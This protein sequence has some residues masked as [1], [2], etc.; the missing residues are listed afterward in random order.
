[1][2]KP[3][4]RMPSRSDGLRPSV[5]NDTGLASYSAWIRET[6]GRGARHA[7][8]VASA[9]CRSGDLDAGAGDVKAAAV[10]CGNSN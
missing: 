4:I 7:A 8:D 3:R 9:R 2:E 5:S 6:C 10:L 1:M